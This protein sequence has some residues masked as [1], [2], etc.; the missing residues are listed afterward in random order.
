[1]LKRALMKRELYN[2]EINLIIGS[3]NGP[4]FISNKFQYTCKELKLEHE[5][6]PFKT[7]TKNTHIEAFHRLLEDECLSRYEFKNYTD[8]Y[9]EVSEYIKSYN[10]VRIHSSIGYISPMEFYQ[11]TLDGTAKPLIIRL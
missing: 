11:R 6:I 3:D 4:Q 2:K 1:M 8:A 10:K 7:P 9:E 5:M